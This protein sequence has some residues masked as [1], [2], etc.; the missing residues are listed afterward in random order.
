MKQ[1]YLDALKKER[2][3]VGVLTREW[4]KEQGFHGDK[5]TDYFRL[6]PESNFPDTI[7]RKDRG[8][9]NLSLHSEHFNNIVHTHT[10]YEFAY[11]IEGEVED[12]V[13]GNVFSLNKGDILIH[14]PGS[15]HSIVKFKEE[16]DI[17]LN[18]TFSRATFSRLFSQVI[19]NDRDFFKSI[20]FS[21]SEVE[22]PKY[23]VCKNLSSDTEVILDLLVKQ[24]FEKEN[25]SA[26]ILES[27]LLLFMTEIFQNYFRNQ[28]ITLG[29]R[30]EN[31]VFNNIETVTLESA[32]AHFNYHPKYFCEVC[33]KETGTSYKHLITQFKLK[34]AEYYLKYTDYTNERISDLVSFKDPVS[35]YSNFKRFY[36][37]TPNEYRKERKPS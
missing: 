27:T 22:S 7:L 23:Y 18:I 35:F 11:V 10:F 2:D 1:Q 14:C 37:M 4:V 33:K 5:I 19:C 31:Y 9:L 30:I 15:K 36:H 20:S 13:E 3:K 12:Y 6:H 28:N 32:A 34:K 21:K 17:L 25:Y 26:P 24:F 29:Q 8:E 16:K